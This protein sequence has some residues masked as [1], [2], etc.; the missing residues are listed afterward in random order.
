MS[1]E[2]RVVAVWILVVVLVVV[3]EERSDAPFWDMPPWGAEIPVPGMVVLVVVL[4]CTTVVTAL[5]AMVVCAVVGLVDANVVV[6][7]VV[8]I[9]TVVVVACVSLVVGMLVGLTR[10]VDVSP[11][12]PKQR[13][14]TWN[15]TAARINAMQAR[16]YWIIKSLIQILL[17]ALLKTVFCP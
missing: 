9:T 15:T 6:G 12:F 5:L 1:P 4:A 16:L 13:H 2:Q 8:L 3:V 11:L 7:M 14:P 17:E 10:V